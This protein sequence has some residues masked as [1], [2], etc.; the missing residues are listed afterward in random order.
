M[1]PGQMQLTP[2]VL[3]RVVDGQAAGEVDDGR[4]LAL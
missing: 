2:D 4:L 1:A 3:P